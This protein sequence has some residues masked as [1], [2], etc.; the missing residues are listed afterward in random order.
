MSIS[1][2]FKT[3]TLL[4]IALVLAACSANSEPALEVNRPVSEAEQPV[5]AT[6][7][8]T[9]TPATAVAATDTPSPTATPEP[10]LP[11]TATLL[12]SALLPDLGPAPD[13]TNEVWLNTDGPL[14]LAAL[15]GEVV[16]VEFWTFG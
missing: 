2:P 16:L 3:A 7:I 15:Q 13:I 12:P 5:E 6:A 11:P 1:I 10:T 4:A 14:N 8:P 9:D